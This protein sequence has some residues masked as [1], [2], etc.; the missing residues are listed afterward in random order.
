V[1]Q[2]DGYPHDIT[3]YEP[4]DELSNAVLAALA[5]LSKRAVRMP[6]LY[7]VRSLGGHTLGD[8]RSEIER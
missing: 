6:A 7:P 5:T 1:N 2:Y 3:T 8:R 4:G